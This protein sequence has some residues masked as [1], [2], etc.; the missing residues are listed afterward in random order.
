LY[1]D[2]G[3]AGLVDTDGMCSCMAR[4]IRKVRRQRPRATLVASEMRS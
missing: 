3:L 1:R 2:E 4:V